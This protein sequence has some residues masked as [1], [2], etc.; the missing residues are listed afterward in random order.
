MMYSIITFNH[1]SDL[2]LHYLDTDNFILSNSEGNVDNEHFD[3]S[4]LYPRSGFTDTP[5]KTNNI[6][7]GKFKHELGSRKIE[8]FI[9]LSPK[10]YSFKDYPKNT[11][12][13]RSKNCK[14]CLI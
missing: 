14:K 10:T 8:E 3:L 6:V 7:P 1:L 5:I 12:E 9:A 4:N 2:Q 11:K 13:K